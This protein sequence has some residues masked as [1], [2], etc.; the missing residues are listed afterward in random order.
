MN[1]NSRTNLK[2]P[3]FFNNLPPV[4]EMDDGD[5]E[6]LLLREYGAVLVARGGAVPP[7]RVIFRNSFEVETFQESVSSATEMI[8]GFEMTLQTAAMGA[9]LSAIN[10][11]EGDGLSITPRGSDSAKRS[12]VD[13][14]ELWAS[15]VQPALDHWVGNGRILPAAAAAM[16]RLRP[17]DQ[18]PEVLKL[19]SEGVWFAKDLFKSIIYSVAPPGASQHLAMLAFDV[20]EF[21]DPSVR[22]IF[23]SHGWHR[24]VV[25]DLPHFTFLGTVEAELPALGLKNVTTPD[26]T[27]WVP[28]I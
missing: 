8:G 14:I 6:A 17:F 20:K 1:E 28:N 9:L 21:A 25:S 26:G 11:A 16:R 2:N 13:T 10:D 5:A 18:V 22:S 27:F 7:D 23:S 19:E 4:F 15:R 12:Y 3:L 24:T